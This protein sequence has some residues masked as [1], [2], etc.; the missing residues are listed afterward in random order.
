MGGGLV[1]LAIASSA[2][3]VYLTQNPDISFYRYVLRKHVNFAIENIIHN[4]QT[5]VSPVNLLKPSVN[6]NTIIF[7]IQQDTTVD[8]LTDLNLVYTFPDIYSSSNYKFKWVEHFGTLLIKEAQL[9]YNGT[10]II[11]KINGEWLIIW[12]EL[13]TPVKDSYNNITGNIPEMTN[14]RTNENIRRIKN[15]IISESDY[16][17]GNRETNIPSI[18][19]RQVIIPLAFFFTRDTS[20]A[21]PL[22]NILKSKT[23]I[24]LRITLRPLEELYTIYSPILNMNV[25]STYYNQLH[26]TNISITDFLLSVNDFAPN[27]YI[28]GTYAC[29]DTNERQIIQAQTSMEYVYQKVDYSDTFTNSSATIQHSIGYINL[30]IKEIIWTL[31][32]LDSINNFNDYFNYTNSIPRN[33]EDNIMISAA[34]KWNNI[35]IPERQIMV[36]ANVY[37]NMIP[38]QYHSCIPRQGIY[39]Y[40]FD[41]M[42][43][44]YFA[45]GSCN[46]SQI[47]TSLNMTIGAYNNSINYYKKRFPTD[48]YNVDKTKYRLSVYVLQHNIIKINNSAINIIGQV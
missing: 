23:P 42:P 41:I 14:P 2:L 34:I 46:G 1:Q 43:E 32:R 31:Q 11:E 25:N 16:P 9:C 19:S 29:I 37:N 26:N 38:Y 10:K 36:N 17:E 18:K 33:N 27:M 30:P 13:T 39:C 28:Y 8:Y 45:S 35:A 21:L 20:L 40:T 15:N 12:L 3:D 47:N 24:T 5:S 22:L 44:K 6:D 4:Y 48:S 7:E